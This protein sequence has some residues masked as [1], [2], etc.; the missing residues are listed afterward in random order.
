[1]SRVRNGLGFRNFVVMMRL[2]IRNSRRC[3]CSNDKNREEFLQKIV[4]ETSLM[5]ESL[6]K[7][8][9]RIAKR[10]HSVAQRFCNQKWPITLAS[11]VLYC[12]LRQTNDA[13][14]SHRFPA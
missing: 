2:C 5:G 9:W 14:L 6:T 4:H 3:N 11:K 1:M 13:C 10:R 12:C 7:F 8:T